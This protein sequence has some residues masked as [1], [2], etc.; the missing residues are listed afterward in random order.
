MELIR[1]RSAWR[2]LL[3]TRRE[4]GDRVGLVPTM[5]ALHA[6]HL[7]LVTAAV[8]RCDFVAMT[9]FV[10]PLQF[11]DAGDLAAYP[12]DLGV[13]LQLAGDSGVDAVFAPSVGEMYPSGEP[14]TTVRPGPLADRLEGIARPSHFEG[15]AT[16]VTKLFALSGTSSAFFGE[17]D[18]Q[19]LA[20][21]SR[22]VVDLDLPIEVVGCPIVREPDGLALASRN[23]RL[24]RAERQA[25]AS[26]FRSLESGRLALAHGSDLD[27]A[28][29]TMMAELT[30]EPL[31]EPG[32]AVAV[33][34]GTLE[35]PTEPGSPLRLLVAAT[36]GPVRLIDNIAA[37]QRTG[38]PAALDPVAS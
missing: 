17:K 33:A 16:V 5:G 29:K 20:I 22:L 31:V 26:L 24:S 28:E 1:E 32:Y 18:F 7:S 8:E 2:S 9:I 12:R 14:S 6:G 37:E 34:P 13:D 25:A 11:G 30:S 15:V 10:N 19:Q 23:R 21:V 35:R 4:R 3:E 27:T 36:V 38:G